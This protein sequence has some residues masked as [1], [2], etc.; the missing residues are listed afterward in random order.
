MNKLSEEHRK[1]L[2][3]NAE[4]LIKRI[5][6]RTFI[7]P[8]DYNECISFVFSKLTEKL[9]SYNKKI[10]K[11]LHFLNMMTTRLINTYHKKAQHEPVLINENGTTETTTLE[12]NYW[13]N[14]RDYAIACCINVL[15]CDS[16][17][18]ILL[19]YYDG[20]T[21]QEIGRLIGIDQRTV[22]YRL[23]K[24]LDILKPKIAERLEEL[25]RIRNEVL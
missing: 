18:I 12:D 10:D 24:A 7:P 25:D 19:Y 21:E 4:Y 5:K 15:P 22:S 16:R 17:N 23:H 11:P 1:I 9:S 8:L 20:K 3:D 2:S 6:G 13:K 14:M